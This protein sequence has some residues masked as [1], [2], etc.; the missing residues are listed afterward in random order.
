MVG[1]EVLV[2]GMR[3]PSAFRVERVRALSVAGS[4]VVDGVVK[5][6]GGRLVLETANGPIPLG[7]PPPALQNMI[8]ARVW[9]SG[10]LDRGPNS[11]G[12]IAPPA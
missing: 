5:N 7:N 4:P 3:T 6:V 10:P 8:G 1:V 12:V 11:Y 9:I 2:V